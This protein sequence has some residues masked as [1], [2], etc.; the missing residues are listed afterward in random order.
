[1]PRGALLRGVHLGAGAPAEAD[2]AADLVAVLSAAGDDVGRADLD[3]AGQRH[4][5]ADVQAAARVG[6]QVRSQHPDVGGHHGEDGQG[7]R[8]Q[9]EE[10]RAEDGAAPSAQDHQVQCPLPSVRLGR[11]GREHCTQDRR[12]L[13]PAA[14]GEGGVAR[15][16]G[17]PEGDAAE[18]P[19]GV[20]GRPS[21]AG[22]AEGVACRV[23]PVHGNA[24]AGERV[25]GHR[26]HGE[27]H[28][29]C[30]HV[31][32]HHGRR[33][34]CRRYEPAHLPHALGRRAD[35]VPDPEPLQEHKPQRRARGQHPAA[36][37]VAVRPLGLHHAADDGGGH[38]DHALHRGAGGAG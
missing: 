3:P 37:G 25:R 17:R 31:L 10:E 30:A 24:G 35:E 28:D 11:P 29:R 14:A 4:L 5:P 22:C 2:H 9:P 32:R 13:G 1:M 36:A 16:A 6:V 38:D 23:P 19:E 26:R 15:Q 33:L 20:Q 12:A 34:G 18:D 7:G 27:S 8:E 21:G